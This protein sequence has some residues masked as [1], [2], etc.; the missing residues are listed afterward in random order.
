MERR[1]SAGRF[2]SKHHMGQALRLSPTA[3]RTAA[4]VVVVEIQIAVTNR[5]QTIEKT[6][7]PFRNQVNPCIISLLRRMDGPKQPEI[8]S[9]RKVSTS[10]MGRISFH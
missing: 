5:H 6:L 10:T 3:A 4:A 7:I 2:K 1:R 9:R 8:D